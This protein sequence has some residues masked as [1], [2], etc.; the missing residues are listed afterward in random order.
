[1]ICPRCDRRLRARERRDQI[2]AYCFRAFAFDPKTN[3]IRLHDLKV[4]RL[5]E[6]LRSGGLRLCYT[7]TQLRYAASRKA[8]NALKPPWLGYVYRQ[9]FLTVAVMVIIVIIIIV[10][11][12]G[13]VAVAT[14]LG[15]IGLVVVTI[16][17]L[18]M[19]P[20]LVPPRSI[21]PPISD[22]GFQA[23]LKRWVRIYGK[24]PPGMVAEQPPVFVPN[25]RVA[26]VCP[27]TSVLSCLS[28]NGVPER[29]SMVLVPNVAAV[30]P[31]VPVILVHDASPAGLRFVAAARAA[32]PDRTVVDAGLRPATVLRRSGLLRLRDRTAEL[33]VLPITDEEAR[34]LAKGW[35]SPV[36]ALPPAKLI[37]MVGRALGR[38]DPDW[39]RAASVG[40][41]TWPG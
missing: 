8:I 28:A 37:A 5:A 22:A 33:P 16:V 7:P 13:G 31:S 1:V 29:N 18:R 15:P 27:D 23:L 41:L 14:V 4:R 21:N 12:Y 9:R 20:G 39:G 34:W 25:P 17:I 36:A 24:P 2:C 26:L 11:P 10:Q 40:F 3:D 19:R 30:P 35:W 6:K 32:L 38:L